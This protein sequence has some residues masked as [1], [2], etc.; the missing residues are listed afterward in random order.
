MDNP[1]VPAAPMDDMASAFPGA[2]NNTRPPVRGATEQARHALMGRPLFSLKLH[3]YLG[4]LL[5]FI[6]GLVV[7]VALLSTS[8]TVDEK[9]VF[10]DAANEFVMELQQARRFEKN[11]FLY[12]TNLPEAI[13]YADRAR[14]IL[15][16]NL[17]QLKSVMGAGPFAIM[18]PHL[19][20][21][22]ELLGR[23]AD[24]EKNPQGQEYQREREAIQ[25]ELRDH[26][27][28]MV[29]LAEN[30]V[31]KEKEMVNAATRRFRT[32]LIFSLCFLTVF[33][34]V[35]TW[36]LKERIMASI[37]RFGS[38]AQ[39][40]AVGDYTPILP[41]RK[42]RDEFSVLAL[43]INQMIDEIQKRED[44]LIQSHKMRAV[45]TLTA[46]VAHELNNPLNNIMLTAHM[47]LEDYAGLD[48]GQRQEM[49]SDM[50][51]EVGRAQKII[52]NL[53]DFARESGSTLEPLDLRE[54]MEETVKLA[55]NQVK[56]SGIK[57]ELSA[58]DNLPRVHGDRQQLQQVFLNLILNAMDASPKGAKIQ[59][60]VLPAD[61]PNYL[62][63]KVVDHGSGIPPHV[64]ASI[65]DPFFTTK[66]PGKGTGLGLS[67]SQ[68]IVVKHGGKIS[69]NSREG[70]GS[71]FTVTLPITT[72]PAEI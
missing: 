4:S 24:L 36:L 29:S 25:L 68:G 42:Y 70:A 32:I 53:L 52:R 21:Y 49:V 50:V 61:E 67:V 63:V 47:L 41:V 8:S 6:F 1:A 40:I 69:V 65:F 28:K 58:V 5:T 3:L 72:I 9:L 20:R 37:G 48:D 19:E 60:M 14:D 46:G 2:Q 56:L 45:G 13:D 54:L 59:I 7:A 33:M 27:Q 18:Q 26:G 62:A 71:T 12:K 39:R 34:L 55:A 66:A 35:V 64:A 17:E 30:L 44:F 11:F 57:T 51:D 38:Y 15:K 23:L 10:L 31:Q 43:A 16:R 22:Q